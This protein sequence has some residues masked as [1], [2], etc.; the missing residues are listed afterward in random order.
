MGRKPGA[1]SALSGIA[2]VSILAMLSCGCGGCGSK[3]LNF[4]DS[5]KPIVLE[6][7]DE[8]TITLD[9]NAT[10]GYQW[11]LAEKPD[12]SVVKKVSEEYKPEDVNRAGAGGKDVWTFKAVG[13]G[14]TSISLIYVRS[15][16][17]DKPPSDA[18]LFSVTVK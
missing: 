11:Q 2:A 7:G 14:D 10:T 4:T 13:K 18:K 9:A 5:S 3:S 6:T 8:F 1:I 12:A 17:E 15:W 16:E